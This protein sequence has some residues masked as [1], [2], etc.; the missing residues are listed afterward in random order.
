MT[1]AT[2]IEKEMINNFMDKKNTIKRV[3]FID[4]ITMIDFENVGCHWT[5]NMSY[6][7]AGGGMNG[8]FK[9]N[10]QVT[11]LTSRTGVNKEATKISREGYPHEKEIVLNENTTLKVVYLLVVP[12]INGKLDYS[13]QERF[14][15]R[16]NTGNRVDKWVK[17]L[18]Y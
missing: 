15:T 18:N 11:L 5:S 13:K 17:N 4:E 1:P 3:I 14:I 8:F 10:F 12:M 6:T 2:D 9:G 7:H 16:G